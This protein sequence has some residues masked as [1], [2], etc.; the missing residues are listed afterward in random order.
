MIEQSAKIIC[1]K[2]DHSLQSLTFIIGSHSFA[3]DLCPTHIQ[4]QSNR[5]AMDC[6]MTVLSSLLMVIFTAVTSL[7]LRLAHIA[8]WQSLTGNSRA[9]YR[10]TGSLAR[11][12]LL[13]GRR[14]G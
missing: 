7:S 10:R 12:N 13:V 2:Q 14:N 11:R 4:S 5:F 6:P 1:Q 3:E 9:G 8:F